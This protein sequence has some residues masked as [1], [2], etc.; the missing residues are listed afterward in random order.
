VGTGD[1]LPHN[2]RANTGGA[3]LHLNGCDN[4]VLELKVPVD[5]GGDVASRWDAAPG[6]HCAAR[7]ANDRGKRDLQQSIAVIRPDDLHHR[8]D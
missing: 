5:A 3:L 2:Q 7:E 1:R 8:D 6:G 4:R